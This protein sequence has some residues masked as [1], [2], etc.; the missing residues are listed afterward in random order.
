MI[1]HANNDFFSRTIDQEGVICWATFD[2]GVDADG[3]S[4]VIIAWNYFNRGVILAAAHK[5]VT[6]FKARVEDGWPVK[7][8]VKKNIS[9]PTESPP[10]TREDLL[11]RTTPRNSR[12]RMTRH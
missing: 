10:P 8:G 5:N 4:R 2:K 7:D 12:R 3:C 1:F 6:P 11:E 9:M